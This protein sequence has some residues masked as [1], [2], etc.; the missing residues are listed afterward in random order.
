MQNPLHSG[1]P[2]I[3]H[4]FASYT[5]QNLGDVQFGPKL[6]TNIG[7]NLH[8]HKPTNIWILKFITRCDFGPK[9]S[10]KTGILALKL[11]VNWIGFIRNWIRIRIFCHWYLFLI[12]EYE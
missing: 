7:V 10:Y 11:G 12:T 8:N 2:A 4:S 9:N 5:D 1:C 6:N 3:S